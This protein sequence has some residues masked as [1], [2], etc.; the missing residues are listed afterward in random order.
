[1]W[2]RRKNRARYRV[3]DTCQVPGWWGEAAQGEEAELEERRGGVCVKG[4]PK[5][6]CGSLRVQCQL[7]PFLLADLEGEVCSEPGAAL[8]GPT[9]R[10]QGRGCRCHWL[11][12]FSHLPPAPPQQLAGWLLL[13]PANP[14]LINLPCPDHQRQSWG[15]PSREERPL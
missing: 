7:C 15:L 14:P 13:G 5:E 2:G 3:R 10:L 12:A 6:A 8:E 11:A 4:V 1:M 9:L